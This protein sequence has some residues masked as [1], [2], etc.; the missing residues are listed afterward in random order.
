MT[1]HYRSQ[2]SGKSMNVKPAYHSA[3]AQEDAMWNLLSGQK[4]RARQGSV[5]R[6]TVSGADFRTSDLLEIEL[7]MRPA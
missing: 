4:L 1:R 6:T 5:K 3:T 2:P 7:M